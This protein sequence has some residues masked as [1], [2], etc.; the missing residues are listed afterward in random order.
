MVPFLW[1]Y[2]V[3]PKRTYIGDYRCGF[4]DFRGWSRV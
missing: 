3:I 1:H 2:K 4:G